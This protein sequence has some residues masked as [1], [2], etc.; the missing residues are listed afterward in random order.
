MKRAFGILAAVFLCLLAGKTAVNAATETVEVHL[1]EAR[2]ECIFEVRWEAAE[3]EAQVRISAPDGT[4]Y[5]TEETPDRVTRMA[6]AAYFYIGDAPDGEW[7]V[8]VSGDS[9]G[10][11]DVNVGSLPQSM[12]IDSFSV[13]ENGRGGYD[14]SW[15]VSDCPEDVTVEIYADTDNQ[16]YD[17]VLAASGG[18]GASGSLSFN[19]P[20]ADSGYY[21]FYMTVSQGSGIF[22]SAYGK[23]AFFYDNPGGDDK[24]P[25]VKASMLNEDIYISWTGEESGIYRVMLFDPD[26]KLVI[27]S[28]ETE[29]DS[30]VLPMPEGYDRVLAAAASY[31]NE[32][33]GRFDVIEVSSGSAVQATV[34]YPEEQATNQ[35]VIYADVSY[36]GE[37]RVSATRNGVLLMEDETVQGKYEISLDEGDNA[38][39]FLV[40]DAQGNT[41]TFL[42]NI[43]LDTT[44]PQLSLKRN[45]DQVKTGDAYIYVE[46]YTEAGATLTCNGQTVELVGSYFSYRQSLSYGKNEIVLTAVDAAGNEAR[47]S[48]EVTRPFWSARIVKWIVLGAAAAV[49][50]LVETVILVKGKRRSRR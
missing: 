31:R 47:Y 34:T 32:S 38:I 43:Y 37:C 9:L 12:K 21:Y 30:C 15:S 46:G 3:T 20:S 48:A 5:G 25:D 10:D 35:S 16:G 11:V 6:G 26:T 28:T 45:L 42:K 7:E 44:P 41:A 14:A 18:R 36:S 4:V 33:L 50:I 39:V 29:E 19:M 22:N 17:G 13:E 23:E 8:S 40:E 1:S 27:S 24:L 2:Q 49:L